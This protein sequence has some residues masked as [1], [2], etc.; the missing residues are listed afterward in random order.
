MLS[1]KTMEEPQ[2][3]PGE[4]STHIFG[5]SDRGSQEPI[6]ISDLIGV[7]GR[8]EMWGSE[9]VNAAWP[10]CGSASMS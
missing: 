4:A 6:F 8:M 9:V 1:K 7:A 3:Q 10:G 2:S 5:G